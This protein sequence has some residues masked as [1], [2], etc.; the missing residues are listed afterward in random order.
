LFGGGSKKN[1]RWGMLSTYIKAF[2]GYRD[3]AN[4]KYFHLYTSSFKVIE[5]SNGEHSPLAMRLLALNTFTL[6]GSIFHPLF[7]SNLLHLH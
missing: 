1:A 6:I 7:I 3:I 4:G 5:M 2:G